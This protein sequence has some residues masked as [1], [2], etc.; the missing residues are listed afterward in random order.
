MFFQLSIFDLIY[1]T[2]ND[3]IPCVKHN[4][5]THIEATWHTFE[6]IIHQEKTE[7]VHLGTLSRKSEPRQNKQSI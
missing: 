2:I 1:R 4:H 7:M 3:G 5:Y 6:I